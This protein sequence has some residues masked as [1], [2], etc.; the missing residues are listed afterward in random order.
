MLLRRQARRD[1][2]PQLPRVV[3]R[4]YPTHPCPGQRPGS[5]HDPLQY[6]L[7]VEALVDTKTRLT[8]PGQA[9]SQRVD[10]SSEFVG[11]AH[12]PTFVATETLPGH[13][14]Q[15]PPSGHRR[16]HP[17]NLLPASTGP[18][19]GPDIQYFSPKS[20]GNTHSQHRRPHRRPRHHPMPQ[21]GAL[22]PRGDP[23]AV[24]NFVPGFVVASLLFGV[25]LFDVPAL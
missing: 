14:S 7:E 3:K 8:Q 13:G 10:L 1:E 16:H 4:G 22:H 9:V 15:Q 5:V 12:T 20:Q 11:L 17:T 6:R 23:G 25:S 2:V 21:R 24:P 19:A 18:Q